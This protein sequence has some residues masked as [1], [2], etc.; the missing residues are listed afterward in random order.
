MP[1]VVSGSEP[2]SSNRRASVLHEPRVFV[3]PTGRVVHR[4]GWAAACKLPSVKVLLALAAVLSLGCG[5]TSVKIGTTGGGTA[6]AGGG[7]AGGTIGTAGGTAGGVTTSAGGAAGGMSC[8]PLPMPPP[9][10]GVVMHPTFAASY[11]FSELGPVPGVPDPLGG[12]VVLQADR[13]HLLIAGAS[14]RM[15][16]GLYRV[17]VRRNACG[18]ITGWVGAATK[19]AATP[20]IDANL[21]ELP[22]GS[23]L[24]TG[25]NVA[26][27]SQ[28]RL[29]AGTPLWT[30]DL[31]TR[32]QV[33]SSAGGLGRVPP[34]LPAAGQFRIV[35]WP[36]GKWHRLD[37]S[38]D[39]GVYDVVRVVDTGAQPLSG[40]PGGF[41]YVP[42]GSALF[43]TPSI[44][45]SEWT[46]NEV[47]VVE[48]DQQGNPV[49]GT[50]RQLF[51]SFPRPW[52]AY[53]EPETGDFL[54]MTW[55]RPGLRDSVFIVQGFEKP[56][57]IE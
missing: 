29:D 1:P 53:F 31:L 4:I 15:T 35:G 27:L 25:W 12:C 51:S 6:S 17:G 8:P 43:S 52:G 33:G 50:R 56:P 13:D 44:I 10:S 32:G 55:G 21:L 11:T 39:A 40:G 38:A 9:D 54:F 19:L 36:D 22:G 24:Y 37:L 2:E 28:L 41:A 23:L 42:L 18:H 16:G 3:L 47:S 48:V 49:S 45:L 20:F 34:W 7:V 26:Q 46:A 57:M 30:V 14:E 5:T